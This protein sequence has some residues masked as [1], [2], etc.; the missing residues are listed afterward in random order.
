MLRIWEGLTKPQ[1]L[2]GARMEE[3]FD[4][5]FVGL[6]HKVCLSFFYNATFI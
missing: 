5:E 3:Y 2:Q 6:P 4:M 1:G